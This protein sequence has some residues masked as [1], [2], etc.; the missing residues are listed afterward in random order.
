MGQYWAHWNC[1]SM[2]MM[3]L[4]GCNFIQTSLQI[5]SSQLNQKYLSTKTSISIWINYSSGQN[6]DS[7]LN[8]DP[9]KVMKIRKRY[10]KLNYIYSLGGPELQITTSEKDLGFVTEKAHQLVCRSY[11]LSD[12]QV[13]GKDYVKIFMTYIRSKQECAATVL[14]HWVIKA[15][16]AA[17]IIT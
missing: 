6:G 1:L 8:P 13:N 5:P 10:T 3:Y 9:G 7:K 12:Y 11:W 2:L 4:R 16:T 14:S 15:H 17:I